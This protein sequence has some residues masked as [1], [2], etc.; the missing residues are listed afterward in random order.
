[1]VGEKGQP[2]T[3]EKQKANARSSFFGWRTEKGDG[4]AEAGKAAVRPTRLF[5]PIYNGLGAALAL[6]LTLDTLRKLMVEY[7]LDGG[8]LRFI[9]LLIVPLL[10]CVSLV[11]SFASP[12]GCENAN[13][14]AVLLSLRRRYRHTGYRSSCPVP[15]KLQVL[16]CH[17]AWCQSHC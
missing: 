5:A 6:A 4:E 14:F 17:Q 11:S 1:M 7:W 12:E 15:P 16:F 9:L 8:K 2:I 3:D 10:F 13:D